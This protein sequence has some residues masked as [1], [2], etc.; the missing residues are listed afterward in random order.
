[1]PMTKPKYLSGNCSASSQCYQTFQ[2]T[3]LDIANIPPNWH[4]KGQCCDYLSQ[5]CNSTSRFSHHA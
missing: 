3:N 4:K 5:S 1:M 2:L